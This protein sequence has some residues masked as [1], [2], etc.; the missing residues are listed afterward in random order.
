MAARRRLKRLEATQAGGW[1]IE[2]SSE[3][4]EPDWEVVVSDTRSISALAT[5]LS[6]SRGMCSWPAISSL[7][8]DLLLVFGKTIQR[9][10]SQPTIVT[11]KQ[12]YSMGALPGW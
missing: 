11:F 10:R 7:L 12:P 4:T 9:C 1:I 2:E 8:F 3:P 6:L 5:S